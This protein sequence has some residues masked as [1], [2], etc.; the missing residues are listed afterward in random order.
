MRHRGA[1]WVIVQ[2]I[3]LA[4]FLVVPRIGPA[5]P[6]PEAF[7][8]SGWLLTVSG[9]VF[10]AWSALSLGRSLTPFPRPLPQGRLVTTGAYR[11]VRHPIYFGVLLACFGFAIA[12]LS[13]LR[14]IL[15]P[16]LFVFFNLKAR[17][18]EIWLQEQYLGYAAYRMRVKKLIPWI[19]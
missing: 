16:G 13:P 14:L 9:I 8:Y 2:A 4:L 6:V 10:M 19:Y 15:L 5:W 11:I 3:L 7:R 17:L 12:T 18:E 1:I